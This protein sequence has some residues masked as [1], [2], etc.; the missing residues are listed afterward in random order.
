MNAHSYSRGSNAATEADD[1]AEMESVTSEL[2][3]DPDFKCCGGKLH[4]AA[5]PPVWK[6]L[7]NTGFGIGMGLAGQAILWKAIVTSELINV[8]IARMMLLGFWT[9]CLMVTSLCTVLYL[10]KALFHFPLVQDEMSSASR[11]HFFNMP[12]LIAMMLTIAVPE[13]P[14]FPMLVSGQATGRVI[15]Y[16]LCLASQLYATSFIYELWLFSAVHKISCST[17]MFF[18]ST[19]GW[20]LLAVLGEELQIGVLVG[21]SIPTFCLSIGMMTYVMVLIAV[22]NGL[23]DNIKNKGSP[24]LFLMIAPPSV[25]VVAFD[26]MEGTPEFSTSSQLLL[27]WCLGLALFLIR[28]GPKI[29]QR[30]PCLGTYWA[31]VFPLAAFANAA[32]RYAWRM[33]TLSTKIFAT[34]SSSVSFL[35]LAI[36]IGR[37]FYHAYQVWQGDDVWDDPLLNVA[38]LEAAKAFPKRKS[39]LPAT[40]EF[41]D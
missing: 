39:V 10:R 41:L 30:P 11:I 13:G 17:P 27:G 20:F 34:V 14:P 18:L 12:H 16:S 26:L 37:M 3:E 7:P 40:N 29:A 21:M 25:G 32:V 5:Y 6:R 15:V 35:A 22:L 23:H 38:S 28:L 4:P 24:A 2:T 19:V 36:V 9:A 8:A 33:Q 1:D 31:Y